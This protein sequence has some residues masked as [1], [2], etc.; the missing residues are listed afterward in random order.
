MNDTERSG[1]VSWAVCLS[2]SH[3]LVCYSFF[4][5]DM[6]FFGEGGMG[7]EPGGRGQ[8]VGTNMWAGNEQK[9]AYS[10]EKVAYPPEKLQMRYD[11]N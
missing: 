2:L 4:T 3:H 11:C 9:A 8:E 1:S 7:N 5:E 10:L 6:T